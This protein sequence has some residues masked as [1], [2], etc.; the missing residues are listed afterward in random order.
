MRRPTWLER[1]PHSFAARV[2]FA[3]RNRLPRRR[4]DRGGATPVSSS[5]PHASLFSSPSKLGQ[6]FRSPCA[7]RARAGVRSQPPWDSVFE[8]TDRE[9]LRLRNQKAETIRPSC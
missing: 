2:E 9:W 3:K 5:W 6:Q 1:I 7:D 4:S 8:T